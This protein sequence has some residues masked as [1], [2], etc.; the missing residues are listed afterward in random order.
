METNEFKGQLEELMQYR[1]ERLLDGRLK[2]VSV[3]KLCYKEVMP[4]S[5]SITQMTSE[6]VIMNGS[7]AANLSTDTCEPTAYQNYATNAL[8]NAAQSCSAFQQPIENNSTPECQKT[9]PVMNNVQDINQ[10]SNCFINPL[11]QGISTLSNCSEDFF[12]QLSRIEEMLRE[13][14]I[15]NQELFKSVIMYCKSY[16]NQQ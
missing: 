3:A 8:Q 14:Y 4:T 1:N 5:K 10:T 2:N 11:A 9:L 13:M 16:S 7:A 12:N 15:T 6:P